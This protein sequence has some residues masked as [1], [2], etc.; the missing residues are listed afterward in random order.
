MTTD[1]TARPSPERLLVLLVALMRDHNL[2]AWGTQQFTEPSGVDGRLG[3]AIFV[4]TSDA[5]AAAWATAFGGAESTGTRMYGGSIFR[6][7]WNGWKGRVY[8]PEQAAP[9]VVMD[10]DT[11]ALVDELLAPAEATS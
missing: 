4:E 1:T 3:F 7:S 8:A 6:V 2:P 11:S 10:A 5:A 9:A